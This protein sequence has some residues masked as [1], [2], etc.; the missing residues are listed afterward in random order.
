MKRL[1]RHGLRLVPALLSL[2]LLAWTLRTADLERS[3]A[4]VRSLGPWL[5]LLLLPNFVAVLAETLG[6][7]LT[8][9]RFGRRPRF[10]SLV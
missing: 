1:A 2:A 3:L 8:F 9:D 5:P 4:L 6:W 7:W 10:R